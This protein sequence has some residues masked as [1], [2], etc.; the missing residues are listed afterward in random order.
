MKVTTAEVAECNSRV[1]FLKGASAH[2]LSKTVSLKRY[3]DT[4]R[5]DT[6]PDLFSCRRRRKPR[7]YQSAV[8]SSGL[9]SEPSLLWGVLHLQF[10]VA[11]VCGGG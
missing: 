4:K 11:G 2:L 1:Q 6:K 8:G 10:F 3:P 7:L 9:L 5:H